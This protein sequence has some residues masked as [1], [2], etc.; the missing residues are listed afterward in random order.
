MRTYL[1]LEGILD[2]SSRM[3]LLYC[4]QIGFAL[5]HIGDMGVIFES[6]GDLGVD[7]A[8]RGASG[9][10]LAPQG[11]RGSHGPPWDHLGFADS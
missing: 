11:L 8:S 9:S 6:L 1:P 10:V 2:V 4:F 3:A 7:S 5:G